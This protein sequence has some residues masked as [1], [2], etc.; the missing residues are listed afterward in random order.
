MSRRSISLLYEWAQRVPYR[1]QIQETYTSGGV[2]H[3]KYWKC[4]L[5]ATNFGNKITTAGEGLTK[6][7]AK[8]LA[9]SKACQTLGVENGGQYFN[10]LFLACA[11]WSSWAIEDL[12][13]SNFQ[14]IAIPEQ[15]QHSGLA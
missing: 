1:A 14:P 3:S 10:A 11:T 9:A 6:K 4:H 7:E 15:P 8:N 2:D 12:A 5:D 13:T